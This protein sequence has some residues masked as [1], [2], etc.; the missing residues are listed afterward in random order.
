[1]G[2]KSSKKDI[3]MS[4]A[5]ITISKVIS[6]NRINFDNNIVNLLIF[7]AHFMFSKMRNICKYDKRIV[8]CILFRYNNHMYQYILHYLQIYPHI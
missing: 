1:M 5:L 4:F 7:F 3:A 6:S 8:N 2:E